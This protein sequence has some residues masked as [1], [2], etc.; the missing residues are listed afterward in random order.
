[1]SKDKEVSTDAG[2]VIQCQAV[3]PLHAHIQANHFT[4]ILAS[5]NYSLR[6]CT[7]LPVHV[8]LP[9]VVSTGLSTVATWLLDS[10]PQEASSFYWRCLLACCHFS[11]TPSP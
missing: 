4:S 9:T 7:D 11:H 5:Y 3:L 6:S 8:G 2:R 10:L 1:M